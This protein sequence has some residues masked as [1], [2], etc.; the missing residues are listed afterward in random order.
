M[1]AD[2]ETITAR[3]TTAYLPPHVPDVP[4]V[5]DVPHA[6]RNY[7]ADF[8]AAV[9]LALLEGGE[10]RFV[11]LL[12][13]DAPRYGAHLVVA[14]FA[15]TYIDP[16]RRATDIDPALLA[17]P[18]PVPVEPSG[19]AALGVGLVF[20]LIGDATPI[21]DRKL[22]RAEVEA[23]IRD[24]YEPYH[25]QLQQM[26]D[27]VYARHGKVWYVDWHSMS[28]IGNALSPDL[29]AERADF[30]LGDRDGTACEQAFTD[31]VAR[32]LRDLG[33]RVD[34]NHPY[35]G[36]ELVARHGLPAQQRHALQIE[37]RRGLY[38]DERTLQPHRGFEAL[39]GDLARI[40]ESICR[41]A[42]TRSG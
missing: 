33:Y 4:V 28:S 19:H 1:Q 5:F 25:A 8:G 14:R 18:W 10:D 32:S 22:S 13:S 12:V 7:P 36:A 39:R 26:L 15:R 16:N 40:A 3:T 9:P 30:A 24:Y 37:M 20:R 23:R 38:M 11:D 27:Q 6:G 34:I 42:A 17:E 29:G 21:Y 35:K 2:D 31:F 41:Y